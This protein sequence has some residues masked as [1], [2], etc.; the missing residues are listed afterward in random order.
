[1]NNPHSNI[2]LNPSTLDFKIPKETEDK[3]LKMLVEEEWEML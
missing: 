1:M 2:S 3:L